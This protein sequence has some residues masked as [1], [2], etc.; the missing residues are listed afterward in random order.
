MQASIV[1]K[2]GQIVIPKSLREKY[3]IKPG[4]K[5]GFIEKDGELINKGAHKRI[6]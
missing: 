3:G 2:K 6:F 1:N 4:T 5:V